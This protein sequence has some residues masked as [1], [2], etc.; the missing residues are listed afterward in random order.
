MVTYSTVLFFYN[1]GSY[2]ENN[3]YDT[4]VGKYSI[5]LTP[6]KKVS[7]SELRFFRLNNNTTQRTG[8]VTDI[9]IERGETATEYEEYVDKKIYTKNDN[10][11]YEKFYDETDTEIYSLNERKIGTWVDGK[12]L[13]R[14]TFYFKNF[15]LQSDVI[16]STGISN[17]KRVLNIYGNTYNGTYSVPINFYNAPLGS[18]YNHYAFFRHSDNSIWFNFFWGT[19]AYIT[20]EYTKTTD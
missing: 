11:V 3:I 20:L 14:K 15:T 16:T 2:S 17:I 9:Q 10:D 8:K 12:P 1:D 18:M 6:T 4:G 7:R 13:Y 5:T 19:E